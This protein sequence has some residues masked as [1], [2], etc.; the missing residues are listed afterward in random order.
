MTDLEIKIKRLHMISLYPESE[1][2]ELEKTKLNLH[3]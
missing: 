1:K 2:Y 3:Y